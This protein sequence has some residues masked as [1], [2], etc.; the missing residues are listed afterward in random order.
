MA[1]D[2][3]LLL[4]FGLSLA[5]APSVARAATNASEGTAYAFSFEMA[6]GPP[7]ALA[8]R[9]GRPMLIVNTASKCGFAAQ[10]T[11]LET[12]WTEY[13]GRGLLVLGVPSGDFGDQELAKGENIKQFC[14]LRFG[15]SFPLAMKTHVAGPEAHPFYRWAARQ[16]P[17]QTPRWNFHKY[18]IGRDGQIAAVFPTSV[19][20]LDKRVVV[21]IEAALNK[22]TISQ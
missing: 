3:R 12:L 9:A 11:S 13:G 19:D 15:V 5:L 2:R 6:E 1:I 7:L 4:G 10:L 21:A 8:E 17:G 16:R 14:A 22:T 18:L 20:P